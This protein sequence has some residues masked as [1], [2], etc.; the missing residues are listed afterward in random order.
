MVYLTTKITMFAAMKSM[1]TLFFVSEMSFFHM[2][3]GESSGF[4]PIFAG[5]FRISRWIPVNPQGFLHGQVTVA[6]GD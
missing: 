3:H 6:P 4:L 1:I 2:F 5:V